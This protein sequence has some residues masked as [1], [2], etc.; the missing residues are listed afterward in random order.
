MP[1]FIPFI[2]FYKFFK[3]LWYIPYVPHV[4]AKYFKTQTKVM[5]VTNIIYL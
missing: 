4:P 1:S 3:Q 5:Y 2:F